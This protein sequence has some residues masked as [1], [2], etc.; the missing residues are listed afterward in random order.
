M[1]ISTGAC[2]IRAIGQGSEPRSFDISTET[3][4]SAKWAG[5]GNGYLLSQFNSA[6][7]NRRDDRWAVTRNGAE[8]FGYIR[9]RRPARR[10]T[11]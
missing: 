5:F 7:A 1:S 10:I 8:R 11:A 6:V 9:R 2:T 3:I 4:N